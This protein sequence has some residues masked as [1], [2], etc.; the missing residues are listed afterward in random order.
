MKKE[1]GSIIV[2]ASLVFPLVLMVMV[3][4]SILIRYFV[5]YEIMQHGMYETTREMSAYYY[6]YSAWGLEATSNGI[7]EEGQ[8]ATENLDMLAKPINA[9]ITSIKNIAGGLQSA[10]NDLAPEQFAGGNV[11]AEKIE[12]IVEN[13]SEET[14][15]L[16]TNAEDSLASVQLIMESPLEAMTYV[17]KSAAGGLAKNGQNFLMDLV[18]QALLTKHI[19][20]KDLKRYADIYGISEVKT[21]MRWNSDR[22][23]SVEMIV[24][25]KFSIQLFG[26][27]DF[28][29]VQRT[30]TKGWGIGV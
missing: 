15:D 28:R 17:L 1:K 6:L 12:Q 8:K 22:K 3:A 16:M 13:L 24:T 5:V 26:G 19:P 18:G 20:G 25:Y 23:G 27:Y 9:T 2:E 11:S 4:F 30:K 7:L 21:S 29:V 14:G 10:Q